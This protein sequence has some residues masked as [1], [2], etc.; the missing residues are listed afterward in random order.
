MGRIRIE[1]T[2][3]SGM[4]DRHRSHFDRPCLQVRRPASHHAKTGVK[5]MQASEGRLAMNWRLLAFPFHLFSLVSLAEKPF[6]AIPF[7]VGTV[8]PVVPFPVSSTGPSV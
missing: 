5:I 2:P 1:R 4:Q 7:R 6:M 8:Q 3:R